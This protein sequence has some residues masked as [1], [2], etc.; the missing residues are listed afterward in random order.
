MLRRRPHA[1]DLAPLT[2]PA[3]VSPEPVVAEPA[4]DALEVESP[5]DAPELDPRLDPDSP[6]E[7]K[8]SPEP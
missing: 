7:G 6:D 8:G 4:V 1:A 2:V 5:V 3:V